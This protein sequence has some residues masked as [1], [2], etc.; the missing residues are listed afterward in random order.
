[1]G[2]H[3]WTSTRTSPGN[4]V[5]AAAPSRANTSMNGSPASAQCEIGALGKIVPCE[6]ASW[7]E[8]TTKGQV[9]KDAGGAPMLLINKEDNG[10]ISPLLHVLPATSIPY[11]AGLK[12]KEYINSHH[13]Q[14]LRL[15]SK[16]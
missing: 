15:Y 10:Y 11:S 8:G 4:K 7:F 1:M 6:G 16:E 14:Q 5:T 2:S 13:L 12:I 3:G 9:V